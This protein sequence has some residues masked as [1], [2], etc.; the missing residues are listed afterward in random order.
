MVKLL[1]A[2][3]IITTTHHQYDDGVCMCSHSA[4]WHISNIIIIAMALLLADIFIIIVVGGTV[5]EVMSILIKGC[6]HSAM[7]ACIFA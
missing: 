7:H 6:M 1:R 3:N 4:A 5:I 2:T